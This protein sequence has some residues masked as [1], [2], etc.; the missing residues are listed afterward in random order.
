MRWALGLWAWLMLSL[1][2][3]WH[4][5]LFL[6]ASRHQAVPLW[7]WDALRLGQWY[8]LP[9]LGILLA[10][11]YGHVWA[12]RRYRMTAT[13]PFLLGAPW[14]MTGLL[15]SFI[16]VTSPFPSRDAMV[17]FGA[18]GPVAGMLPTV[19]AAVLG[20]RWSLHVP[21]GAVSLA[22]RFGEP[23]LFQLV[24]GR[25][26]LALHPLAVAG[27]IGTVLTLINLMPC[28]YLDGGRL[29]QGLWPDGFA[30]VSF[31]TWALAG[32]G[33]FVV[34]GGLSWLF[35]WLL[36]GASFVYAGFPAAPAYPD[37]P[38]WRSVVW[39]SVAAVCALLCWCP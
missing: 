31:L 20:L 29:V 4:A 13:G 3:A 21:H 17:E 11:E 39:A 34:D 36:I 35:L 6:E 10:H 9:M 38:T 33:I 26:D 2:G 24:A 27:W 22:R 30:A 23:L 37:P 14:P 16:R 12:L 8:A 32:F 18:A 19:A 5:V 1:S 25:G 15:G 28:L 7:G